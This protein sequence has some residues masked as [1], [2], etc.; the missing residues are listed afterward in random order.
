MAKINWLILPHTGKKKVRGESN[1]IL[2][3]DMARTFIEK[4]DNVYFSVPEW[5]ADE[6][7]RLDRSK[8]KIIRV[9]YFGS[10]YVD[11]ALGMERITRQFSRKVSDSPI[12]VV[13]TSKPFLVPYLSTCL[14]DS[15]IGPVPVLYF[16]PGVRDK[17]ERL[18]HSGKNFNHAHFLTLASYFTGYPIFLTETEKEI[19]REYLERYF[20]SSTIAD[21]IFNKSIVLPV[22]VPIQV[23]DKYKDTPKNE[24]FTLFFGGR[25]NDVKRIAD[26][27]KLYDMFY[28]SGRKVKIE[29]CTST[30]DM[31]AKRYI[32]P[33]QFNKNRNIILHTGM[34][35]D[36]YLKVAAGAHCFVAWSKREGF[37]VGLWEQMYL[38]LVGVFVDEQWSWGNIP[39][40]YPYVFNNLEEGF[41]ILSYLYDHYEEA[42]DKVK[43]MADKASYLSKDNIYNQIRDIA[44]GLPNSYK[45]TNGI[46]GLIQ[47]CLPVLGDEF[48]LSH[49]LE[50]MASKGRVFNKKN[51]VRARTYRYPSNYDIY[52]YLKEEGYDYDMQFGQTDDIVFRHS[53]SN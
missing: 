8:C 28:A 9:P 46:K 22:G 47:E 41:A 14:G 25:A 49:L 30:P 43:F 44:L 18:K 51:L 39:K 35:R 45:M 37:P 3:E 24:E 21:F 36:S 10:Y 20:T 11:M 6:D 12:D 26:I 16:E 1:Y 50:M 13:I 2:F 4:G 32:G 29:L 5:T 19:A 15:Q 23:L 17:F 31:L 40:D 48:K 42:R 52:R 33:E 34:D 27:V 7:I 38:G 53:N